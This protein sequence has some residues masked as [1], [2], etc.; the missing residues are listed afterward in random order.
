MHISLTLVLQLDAMPVYHL[1]KYWQH[2]QQ[3]R[4]KTIH[5][6]VMENFARQVTINVGTIQNVG[7]AQEIE[8]SLVYRHI[9]VM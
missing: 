6:G 3:T 4:Q 1:R 7:R 5:A 2:P 9:A 8:F